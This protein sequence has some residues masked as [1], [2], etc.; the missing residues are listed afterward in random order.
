MMKSFNESMAVAYVDY[1][2]EHGEENAQRFT[3][4]TGVAISVLNNLYD[5]F[6]KDGV[7][8]IEQLSKE[9]KE[10]FYKVACKYHNEL[11]GQLKATKA[12]YVLSL[13]T[14]ND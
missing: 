4:T 12:C 1:Y 8:P 2:N 5:G 6:V 11:S 3:L 14:S 13:I 7:M 10:K 9:L